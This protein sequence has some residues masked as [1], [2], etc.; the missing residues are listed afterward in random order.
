MK[1]KNKLFDKTWKKCVIIFL[2]VFVIVGVGGM[3]IINSFNDTLNEKNIHTDVVVVKDKMHS[4]N[5]YNYFLI[6][7]K[8]NKTYL[9]ANK[10]D[11]YSVKMFEQIDI[12]GKYRFTVKE[13]QIDSGAPQ[14]H[15]IKVQ[16][17]TS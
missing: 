7:G 4:D 9:I 12:G 13:K 6:I 10:D 16:N 3:L 15:I 11:K 2:I 14:S 1:I 5:Q 8:N 17:A